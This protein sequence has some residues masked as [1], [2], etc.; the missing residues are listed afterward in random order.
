M[1]EQLAFALHRTGDLQGAIQTLNTALAKNAS[2]ETYGLLGRI[3]K[4][5]WTAAK[6]ERRADAAQ[7]LR[8]AIKAYHDGFQV[9]WRDAYP[10]INAVTLMEMERNPDPR[11]RD[12]LPVVR[13]AAMQSVKEQPDYWDH[14]TLLELAVLARDRSEAGSRL[15][16]ALA[17]SWEKWQLESTARNLGLI[18]DARRERGE[19]TDW[20]AEIEARLLGASPGPRSV[21]HHDEAKL[22]PQLQLQE[23]PLMQSLQDALRRTDPQA[24][25]FFAPKSLRAGGYWLPSLAEA[26]ADSTAF[27]L[28]V[29][30]KGLGPWQIIEYYEALDRRVKEP[31]YP[32]VL[33]LLEG[34]PHQACLFSA[35]C[36][37][38]S[39]RSQ[40]RMSPSP[41]SSMPSTRRLRLRGSSGASPRPIAVSPRWRNPIASSSSGGIARPSRCSMP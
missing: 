32:V 35:S 11:Q 5:L 30:E 4:D 40:R 12:L 8:E 3:Y 28:L 10:G 1:R 36:T 6:A 34:G 25:V 41:S 9:D 29:G 17:V 27:V 16:D 31:G 7:F 13:Y 20:I 14:A 15:G 26:I 22:V 37:G 18:R 39:R 24:D 19:N 21:L 2:S 23:L 38:S 33:I